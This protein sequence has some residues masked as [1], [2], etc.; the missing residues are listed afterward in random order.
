MII[1]PNTLFCSG[2][3]G[4]EEDIDHMFFD[5]WLCWPDMV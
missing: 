2:G 5:L 3:C 4:F 1:S